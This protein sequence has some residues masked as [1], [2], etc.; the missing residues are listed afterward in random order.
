MSSETITMVEL[1]H[2]YACL[3]LDAYG[4][5]VHGDGPVPGAQ[6][7]IRS[8]NQDGPAY[9]VVTNDASRSPEAASERYGRFGLA[10][11]PQRIVTSGSLLHPYFRAHRLQGLRCAVLGPADSHRYVELAG[12]EIVDPA[13]DFEILVIGDES[14]L[15]P[16]LDVMNTTLTTLL[17]RIDSGGDITLLL[18]NPDLLFPRRDGAVGMT[19]GSIA[20]LVEAVLAERYPHRPDLRFQR[21]GKPA[22]AL[23]EEA[24]RRAGTRSVVMIGDQLATDIRGANAAEI[25]SALFGGGLSGLILPPQG[26][27]PTYLLESLE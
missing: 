25:D 13:E 1:R 8:L 22:T 15:E 10:V 11:P 9:F 19:S 27:R 5:L 12:G 18:P 7:L 26:P 17:R 16:F 4:V 3:L 24:C 23:F 21:L 14:G 20:A 2:R 6:K